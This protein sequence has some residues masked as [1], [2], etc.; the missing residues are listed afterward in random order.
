[1]SVCDT[2]L[3]AGPH[4]QARVIPVTFPEPSHFIRTVINHCWNNV[5]AW[6]TGAATSLRRRA[7]AA[8][9]LVGTCQSVAMVKP[10]QH[11]GPSSHCNICW[12]LRDLN[13]RGRSQ[14]LQV[15]GTK[16]PYLDDSFPNKAILYYY[17]IKREP[18]PETLNWISEKKW[19]T[20]FT[21]IRQQ[22]TRPSDTRK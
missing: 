8:R 5:V 14:I 10:L 17:Y 1:M 2:L 22:E 13:V 20:L 6:N 12:H 3:P 18:L 21:F 4:W 15:Y 16:W 7:S 11:G 19:I 9:G